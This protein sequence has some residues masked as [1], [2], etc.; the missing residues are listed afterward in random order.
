MAEKGARNFALR[1]ARGNEIG[2]FAGKQPRQDACKDLE[3][4]C[5]EG[6]RRE[7]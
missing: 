6:R 2:V 5:Q 1:D 4:Q 7:A 3:T